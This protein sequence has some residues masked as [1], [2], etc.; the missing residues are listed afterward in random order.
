VIET[1]TCGPPDIDERA[2]L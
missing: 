2:T 1:V